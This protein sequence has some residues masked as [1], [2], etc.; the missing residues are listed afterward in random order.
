MN[1]KVLDKLL[2]LLKSYKKKDRLPQSLVGTAYEVKNGEL[3]FTNMHF[4]I[5]IPTELPDGVYDLETNL[6]VDGRLPDF[7]AVRASKWLEGWDKKYKFSC[8][9]DASLIEVLAALASKNVFVGDD[10]HKLIKQLI[11]ILSDSFEVYFKGNEDPIIFLFKNTK[12]ELVLMP[13]K[14]KNIQVEEV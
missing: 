13:F 11:T 2:K 8:S 4:A 1:R 5:Y 6:P 9:S 3:R 14:A 10:Y 12:V 7:E